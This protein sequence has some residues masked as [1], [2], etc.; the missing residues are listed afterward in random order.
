MPPLLCFRLL[1]LTVE[2]SSDHVRH[3]SPL[4]FSVFGAGE[5]KG[6]RIRLLLRLIRRRVTRQTILWYIQAN[7]IFR[8]HFKL[9]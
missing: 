3:S 4:D 2:A 7:K 1:L 6:S 9:T 5:R 8:K